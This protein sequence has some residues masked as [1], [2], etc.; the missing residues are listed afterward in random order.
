M[1]NEIPAPGRLVLWGASGHGKVIL[2][3][4]KAA[5]QFSEIVFIDDAHSSQPGEFYGH[6]LY[7]PAHYF[8]A[9]QPGDKILISIGKNNVRADRF[10]DALRNGVLPATVI[11]PSAVVSESAQID[12][13]TVVMPRVVVN[14]AAHIGADCILNTAAVIEHDCRIG[15]HVHLSPGV[16]LAGGVTVGSLSHLGIG[17]VVLPRVHIGEAVTVGAGAVVTKAVPDGAIVVGV[18]AK[19]HK[20][21]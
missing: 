4:A 7:T 14:S 12:G 18:P 13:G 5:Q 17:A 21:S 11:H 20:S 19:P 6:A 10:R 15:A 16:L 8:S 9:V 1:T 3:A 2:D